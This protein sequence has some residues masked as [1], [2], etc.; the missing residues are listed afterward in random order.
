M[1][2]INSIIAIILLLTTLSSCDKDD[3][4]NSNP[5]NTNKKIVIIGAGA[6]GLAAA[7]HFKENGIDVIVLEAQD[8]VGGRLKTDGSSDI[9][10][11]EGASWI[12]GPQG[13]PITPL[14]TLA[15]AD[16]FLT[17]DNNIKVYDNNGTEYTTAALIT[18][19]TQYGNAVNSIDGSL[20][21]SFGNEFYDVYTQYQN[22]RLWT[23]MLSANLEFDTGGDI[24]KLSSTHFYDDEAFT[25]D[26]LIITNGFDKVADYLAQ[27]IDVRLNNK[28]QSI[29]YTNETTIITTNQGEY[30][31]D[32]VLV[33]V[34]LGICKKQHH[35]ICSSLTTRNAKCD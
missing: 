18:A 8:K 22:N 12:H 25:G 7:K 13:N 16:T 3:N 5:I 35:N 15:G 17:D 2:K 21:Q 33:T 11:Y 9:A 14:A 32:Y 19:E 20:N 1:K 6:S 10:F 29:N 26:D 28:V 4:S 30:E 23:F 34:P 31:A 27:S 24:Y